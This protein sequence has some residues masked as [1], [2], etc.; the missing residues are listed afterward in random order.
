MN[1]VLAQNV[2]IT[3]NAT[4]G[5]RAISPNIYGRNEGFSEFDDRKDLTV[6]Q[7]YDLTKQF[8]KDAG[9]RFVRIG[10]GNNMSAYNW[11]LKLDVHPDWYNN[12]YG[13][14]W[15][16]MA[17]KI[18]AD[19]PNMKGMFAFQLLG[20]AATSSDYNFKD[21]EYKW[22][23]KDWDGHGQNL[24]GNGTL[25]PDGNS[26]QALVDGNIDLFSKPWP[27][28]SSV[29]ILDSWFGTN[30]KGFNV[31]QLQYWSMDNEPDCWGGTHDW[32]MK[33]DFPSTGMISASAF[34]DRFIELAYKAKAKNPNIKI[35]GPVATSEWFWYKWGS[36]E[37]IWENGKY[38]C[39]IQYVI[40]RC[41]QEYKKTGVKLL[42]VVDIHN[43]PYYANNAEALQEHRVYYDINYNYSG[44]NG[45][46]SVYGGWD[47]SQKKQYIFKRINDWCTTEFGA[48]HGITAGVSEWSPGPSEPN[49]VS[50]IYATHLGT[51]ANNGVELFSPWNWFTGMWETLHLF[52]R[53]GKEFS[54]QST[55]TKEDSVSAYSSINANAD[56]MTI[57]LVN[58]S[59]A[60]Q[61]N[62]SVKVSNMP[63][64]GTYNTLSL[65]NL[66]STET[67]VSH[68]TNALKSGTVSVLDST[69]TASLP[70]LS[71]TA[72]ILK[73][74]VQPI[75]IRAGK[76]PVCQGDNNIAFSI[77]QKQGARYKWTYSGT[78][79]SINN[80]TLS[81]I[82]IN[83]NNTAT[84]GT[85][86]VNA[87]YPADSTWT[88]DIT[89]GTPV[90][91]PS[92]IVS[93]KDPV[94]KGDNNIA[95]S[96]TN[97]PEV[98]YNW[99]YSGTGA[100]FIN[101]DTNA[102]S[103]NY[104]LA[105]TSG[106]LTVTVS[107]NGC[108]NSQT[109]NVSV[110]SLPAQPGA[111]SASKGPVCTGDN[112][113]NYSV[114]NDAT[115]SYNW[116]YS[117]TGATISNAA[118][119]A[120]SVNYNNTATSGSI[121][122]IATNA[123]GCSSFRSLGVTVNKPPAQ[124]SVITASK[125]P[126]CQGATA[127]YYSVINDPS[128]TYNW[129]YSGTGATI[130][131]GT[132]Y[133]ANVNYS[134]TATSGTMKVTVANTSGCV[135]ANTN[136]RT[137][138]VIINNL[139]TPGAIIASKNPV[140]QGD[141]GITYSVSDDL[142]STYKWTYSGMGATVS[143]STTST[144]S[145]DYS[146]SATSGNMSVTVSNTGGCTI[147]NIFA[148]TVD[149]KTG[150]NNASTDDLLYGI[151]NS[152]KLEVQITYHVTTAALVKIELFNIQGR[153]IKSLEDSYKIPG[154]YDVRTSTN[155]LAKGVYIIRFS[156]GT[157][158]L[159]KKV[160]VIE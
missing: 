90:T 113:I 76:N 140:I 27:A 99:T 109:A 75:F 73:K 32:V 145:V 30:G 132:S 46:R 42:D 3:V 96:V 85:L 148:V 88:L 53:Y 124:P 152:S 127:V 4:Q 126:V 83:F 92:I 125:N 117:G 23:H 89:V 38:Y 28:D 106:L 150:I 39:W 35:C 66:P 141:N 63:V 40:H 143:N 48:N 43:Y 144:S 137:F 105:A 13:S 20:R 67:F 154:N 12:V 147:S 33:H 8:L 47:D 36:N 100:T 87:K 157:I 84:S 79:V 18:N 136:N 41:G 86:T 58:R 9:L 10:G 50:V 131:F 111:I 61:Q 97:D 135:D 129:S 121:K 44:S 149:T 57:F 16:A 133:K 17:Q 2:T 71:V 78:G 69:F 22:D 110:N 101:R 72:V 151:F 108:S 62:V 153:L 24:A 29:A 146:S 5:K 37:S 55:S 15:D 102:I 7:R 59:T 45:I 74:N 64:Y 14:D 91:Q 120:V 123:G 11:R 118:T 160:L 77:P 122:V 70:P 1:A 60:N 19:F 65:Y 95:Y 139:P 21:W 115:V 80:D 6:E 54:I 130:F 49:Y 142:S 156:A 128:V 158:Q 159:Q 104:G 116:T 68:T 134:K 34:M 31:N 51:F 25:N 107:N 52:S 81:A 82:N 93:G 98:T 119:N 155:G 103:V 112:G 114:T 26:S 94:C 56:S 138:D